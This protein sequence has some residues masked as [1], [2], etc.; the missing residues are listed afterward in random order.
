MLKFIRNLFKGRTQQCN[1][2]DVSSSASIEKYTTRNG[3]VVYT[4][5]NTSED[6]LRHYC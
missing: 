5:T 2:P 1:I 3:L 4:K 6:W